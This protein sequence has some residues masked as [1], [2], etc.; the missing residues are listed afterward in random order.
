[1]KNFKKTVWHTLQG[2]EFTHQSCH[3]RVSPLK[4]G[5][6]AESVRFS[7]ADPWR[8]REEQK[9]S[10][11]RP[12]KGFP[13]RVSTREQALATNAESQREP[14]VQ[15]SSAALP[16]GVGETQ[17]V[18]S[19]GLCFPPGMPPKTS[20]DCAYIISMVTWQWQSSHS[21]LW[22]QDLPL[23]SINCPF[24]VPTLPPSSW[25]HSVKK[26]DH[27]LSWWPDG[28]QSGGPGPSLSR[29]PPAHPQGGLTRDCLCW[30]RTCNAHGAN[31]LD[32]CERML[33]PS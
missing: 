4:K 8:W 16:S 25:P 10:D 1:M 6:S 22:V 12:D 29:S 18:D 32:T 23:C 28:D 2:L 5:T 20:Y 30:Q 27:G 13:A 9:H 33:N 3:D 14:V 26:E 21:T 11:V 19:S 17:P 24:C 31:G 15:D 7:V